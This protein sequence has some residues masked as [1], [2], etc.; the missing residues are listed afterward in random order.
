MESD[1]HFLTDEE[2]DKAV[3]RILKALMALHGTDP[4]AVADHLGI[5][6]SSLSER[7]TGKRRFTVVEIAKL[8]QFFKVS[9]AT[10]FEDPASLVRATR[11]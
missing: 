8:A 4:A 6:K 11:V 3:P 1:P 7:M 9:P 5:A 2:V 10:F